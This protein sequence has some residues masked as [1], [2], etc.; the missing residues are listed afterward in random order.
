MEKPTEKIDITSFVFDA[1]VDCDSIG[2][3]V[4]TKVSE[5]KKFDLLI[6]MV[7]DYIDMFLTIKEIKSLVTI[8][9]LIDLCY[10]KINS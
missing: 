7:E 3:T 8:K 5:I 9:D 2:C 1:L 4:E 10:Q 6:E